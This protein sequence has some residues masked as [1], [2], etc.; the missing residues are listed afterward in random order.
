MDSFLKQLIG[1]A[2]CPSVHIVDD[3]VSSAFDCGGREL[4]SHNHDQRTKIVS[5]CDCVKAQRSRSLTER[6]RDGEK[7]TGMVASGPKSSGM[8]WKTESARDHLHQ[9]WDSIAQD[10]AS[11]ATKMPRRCSDS[12]AGKPRRKYSI[13]E[14]LG[15]MVNETNEP[16]PNRAEHSNLSC[17]SSMLEKHW[18]TEST[19]IL[20]HPISSIPPR[21]SRS[22][23]DMP[24]SPSDLMGTRRIYHENNA[25]KQEISGEDEREED[26]LGKPYLVALKTS[27]EEDLLRRSYHVLVG[28]PEKPERRTSGDSLTLVAALEAAVAAS[29]MSSSCTSLDSGSGD[30]ITGVD[31]VIRQGQNLL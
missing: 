2:C 13:D 19:S 4:I 9:R 22:I 27:S 28:P 3:N 25:Q 23:D 12:A 11:A 18:Q 26:S 16:V 20:P 5:G 17:F 31:R 10:G 15:V 8:L 29:P 21:L 30:K 14:S 6:Q 24:F 1:N 7:R